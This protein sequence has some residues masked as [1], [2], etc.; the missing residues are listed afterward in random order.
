MT[1]R[2]LSAWL[3]LAVWPAAAMA[4]FPPADSLTQQNAAD[5][6]SQAVSATASVAD[7]SAISH[8]GG[9]SIRMDTTA[10]FDCSMWTPQAKNAD[11][12]LTPVAR[13][14]FW[15]RAVNP[16][17]AFQNQSPWVALGSG[18]ARY[19]Y[20]PAYD[21]LNDAINTWI[22]LDIPLAG[23]S[24]WTRTQVGGTVNLANIDYVEIH[25]D[26]W[27]AGFSM[28]VDGMTFDTTPSL[29]SG[30]SAIAGNNSVALAWL[31]YPASSNFDHFA[32]Y[33]S[34]AAFSNVSGMTPIATITNATATSHVDNTAINGMHYHY[35]VT[36]VGVGG[37]EETDVDSL[38]PRTPHDE[39]DLGVLYIERTPRYPRY[40][41]IYTNHTVTEPG[42]FG[43]YNFSA[44]TGL[45]SGQ[46]AGT[47]RFPTNGSTVTYTVHVRNR[48]TNTAPGP[49]AGTWRYDNV[50]I[51]SASIAGPLAPGAMG[52]AAIT[53]VWDGQS[54][55]ITFTID[56]P[57]A[58]I[59][60]NSLADS[61]DAV[62][63]LS[64]IDQGYIENF[65][66]ET[67]GYP[68]AASDDFVYWLH[69]HLT[70]MNQMF[71]D[72]GSTK[73][74]RFDK[75]DVLSDYDADPVVPTINW[76][77]FPFR[78]RAA[79]GSLRLSGYYQADVD[80]DYGLLHEKGHQLGLIDLYRLDLPASNNLASGRGY[81]AF[82]CLMHGVSD[83]FSVNSALAMNHWQNVAHGYYGQY[84]YSMPDAVKM[85]FIGTDG[86]SLNGAVVKMYQKVE[87]P[88][89]GEIIPNVIK[90]QG[91]TDSNGEWTLPNVPINTSLVPTTFAGDSL[92]PNPF[93]YVAV[94][95]TNG[96]LHFRVEKD[97]GVDY[98]WLEITEVNNA[99]WQ[100]QTTVATFE[101]QVTL[102]GPLQLV[103]LPDLTELNAVDWVAYAEGSGPPNTFVADET[104]AG[105]H[106]IGNGSLKFVT[107]GGF[108]TSVRYP[109]PLT[110]Q[111]DLSGATTLNVRLRTANSN[112][113]FQNGSPWIRLGDF[114]NNYFEYR[115]Y[116]NGNPFDLLNQTINIWRIYGIPLNAPP[117]PASGWGRTVV[118]SPSVSNIRYIEI[119]ADTWGAGFTMWVDGLSF[120]PQPCVSGDL[121][122]DSQRNGTDVGLFVNA[123]LTPPA[124]PL[125]LCAGDFD[126]SGTLGE[127]D[128]AAFVECV[129]DANA[130][131]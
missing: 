23:S 37:A 99:Y 109:G 81:V 65:R 102:G 118:G 46:N 119:H 90:A 92:A 77:I 79:D 76:A 17:L 106:P 13:L 29:P 32:V 58:R 11:W 59:V 130:C 27:G 53:R 5:W 105:M 87:V 75:L 28:W 122:S 16:N 20:R 7:D 86:D 107:D 126:S 15:V 34:T 72:A 83:F 89:Q 104:A 101:R 61:T 70:E 10:P 12:D 63:F 68:Q 6:G 73:R 111:W 116:Q 62:G 127:Q 39:T 14:Q 30:L 4:E 80:I 129:L 117:N 3:V 113:G 82:P 8:E 49:I 25:A 66:E 103:P 40:D 94:V 1:P 33:R 91:T 131:P 36:V 60:N 93:G 78:Y 84:L 108:D 112:I 124:T 18:V 57:D 67:S 48:G 43:P 21:I 38:G 45:G 97:G 64:F 95:G 51:G 54:H 9:W 22:L 98:S 35:A 69:R 114:D 26:T 96:L 125:E 52:T 85:R 47:Q 55:A 74:V 88:G 120:S 71:V 115:Y 31:T 100:G 128:I 121:N 56:T 50:V 123:V 42:G 19:E 41:P 24:F 44:A 110:A 2:F